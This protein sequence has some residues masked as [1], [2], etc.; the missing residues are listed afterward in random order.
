[1]IIFPYNIYVKHCIEGAESAMQQAINR[2]ERLSELVGRLAETP[3]YLC[4]RE[5]LKRR[6]CVTFDRLVGDSFL[7]LA[8]ALA[9][10]SQLA[11]P[12]PKHKT[13]GGRPAMLIIAD[14]TSAVDRVVDE[15]PLFTD[16]PIVSFP[17][18]PDQFLIEEGEESA[19][20]SLATERLFGQRLR[21][22]KTLLR[23]GT[24]TADSEAILVTT[25][26][27]L[28]Q[29]IPSPEEIISRTR[30]LHTGQT[31]DREELVRWLEEAGFHSSTSVELPGE[32][33]IRGGICDLFA[34]DW[35]RP[36]RIEFFG[37]EIDS[38]RRFDVQTQRSLQSLSSVDLTGLLPSSKGRHLLY[39][40]LPDHTLVYLLDCDAVLRAGNDL[41]LYYQSL[42]K[43]KNSAKDRTDAEDDSP[44]SAIIRAL[45]S[46]PMVF[47][48][49]LASGNEPT[50]QT[51]SFDFQTVER[52]TGSEFAG[53]FQ[54]IPPDVE[55]DLFCLSETEAGRMRLLLEETP[56]AKEGRIRYEVGLMSA[57]FDAPSFGRIV[58]GSNEIFRRT[59]LHRARKPILSS[60][61]DSFT[62]LAPGDL[63]I[64]V[65]H[66][67]ARFRGLKMIKSGQ[68]EEE[69]LELE[70]AN[71]TTLCGPV[72]KI[73]LV[74]KYVGTGKKVP[75]LAKLNGRVWAR[76]KDEVRN[77][78]FDMA[79]ELINI[80]ARRSA[81]EG[82][83]FPQ[84][85]DLQRDFEET[86]PFDE[87]NDQLIAIDEIKSDMESPCPMDRLLCGDVGFGKTE[88]AV[89]AAFKAVDA[90]YQVAV[91][92]PTTVLAEQHFRVF[93][94]R[95]ASFPVKIA[96]LSRFV[97]KKRETEIL[98]QLEDGAIDIVIGTHRI[99]QKDVRFQNLGLV[100]IDEEQKFGVRDKEHL[101]KL[102][103]T[104]DILTMT[105]T[106]IPRTLHFSLLKLRS[107]SKLQTPPQ[108][109]LPVITKVTPVDEETIR[110]AILH[111][112]SRGGQVYY[113]H[114]RVYDIDETLDWLRKVVP[115]ARI[116]VGHA[117]MSN[118][119]LEKVMR[120]FFRHEIDVLLCTTI[121]ES[122][123]DIIN[124]NTIFIEDAERFGL[125]ELHQLRGR[126]GR[127]RNQAYCYLLL[128]QGRRFTSDA[129][130]RLRAIEEF[131]HLGAGF[132]LAM[133]DLEIRG[134]GNIL[135]TAQSGHIAVV[136]YEMYCDI[137]DAAVRAI[138]KEPQREKIE[139]GIDLPG[140]TT[141]PS[142]YISD[143]R[144]KIDIYRRLA[145]VTAMDEVEAISGEIIDR[146][147]KPPIE[148]ERFLL[149]ARIRLAAWQHRIKSI[150]LSTGPGGQF[151][152]MRYF[153]PRRAEELRR[154]NEPRR[155]PIRFTN[156]G[157][158]HIP[159]PEQ[160]ITDNVPDPDRLLAY[161]MKALTPPQP[162]SVPNAVSQGGSSPLA[163]FLKKQ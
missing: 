113:L 59:S 72:S 20:I 54:I 23:G 80:Q 36:V 149:Q 1:M 64:H 5:I 76:Q 118:H 132:Q 65:A 157:C 103:S 122:G 69:N 140:L 66:G 16:I 81:L 139:V 35:E 46:Y 141:I 130:K 87:T 89:R 28:A 31:I 73:T 34:P 148:T 10:D 125:A 45:D 107:I 117:Q 152:T 78:V 49:S 133:R 18:L 13:A 160:F 144:A 156:D 30:L 43:G 153:D 109:R 127:F 110:R 71:N 60:A 42:A 14:G 95:M 44:F 61:I 83:R 115:E 112:M 41:D 74:Q 123:L 48:T 47:A 3:S 106:P 9:E 114:N 88:V 154:F 53:Q 135:G 50:D 93:S 145:R 163:K 68:Q 51:F 150:C 77:A 63:V 131:S 104:V 58:L 147:G 37:D 99:V 25:P 143:Q 22:I 2:S 94:E 142:D 12:N 116:A 4:G 57:G 159:V 102:R 111:E 8:A 11:V 7:L 146:F 90:G 137:L 128:N 55:I 92:V 138:K 79:E 6:G 40:H 101:K 161:L 158:L 136:G 119:E 56:P 126:V 98:K 84:D 62:D 82:V 24:D 38:I 85:S 26:M 96:V 32:Y 134:A 17:A 120:D 155:I 21:A 70:F 29:M 39:D 75:P 100:I 151:I 97:D 15:L 52:F 129:V 86:F 67:L 19:E 108:D 91:L 27:A 121:I 105:A 124:A 162:K 33:S